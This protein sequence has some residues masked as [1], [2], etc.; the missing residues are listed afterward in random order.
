VFLC[1]NQQERHEK[2]FEILNEIFDRNPKNAL[3]L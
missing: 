2:E 3:L 1:S